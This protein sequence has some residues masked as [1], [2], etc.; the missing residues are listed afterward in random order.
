MM[1]TAAITFGKTNA[2]VNIPKIMVKEL[3]L[4]NETMVQME[5]VDNKIIITKVKNTSK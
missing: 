1:K 2:F 3:G 5:M 4:E